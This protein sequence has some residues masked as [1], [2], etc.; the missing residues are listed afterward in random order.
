MTGKLTRQDIE[1]IAVT[2]NHTVVSF[3]NYKNVHS[4]IQVDCNSCGMT[5]TTTVHKYKNAKKTGCPECKKKTISETQKG[6]IT[7]TETKRKIGEK[8]SQRP[9]SL[10]GK[11]GDQHPRL[12][13]G[14]ARDLKNPS[15]ADYEWK[16]AVRERCDLTC[17]VTFEKA[18][19]HVKGFVC[20]H[21][22]SFSL[23]EDLRFR[24]KNGVY[25]KREIHQQFHKLYTLENTTEENFADFCQKVHGFD[26]Y[27]RKK[28]LHLE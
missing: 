3:E 20:H 19:G 22:N 28:D 16:S 8:T 18:K 4:E 12:K 9:G 2:R 13:G 17:V 23:H 15:T 27:Q 11:T 21:L 1:K 26:W 24:P 10:T 5:W 25:L 7:S 6:Q 14:L